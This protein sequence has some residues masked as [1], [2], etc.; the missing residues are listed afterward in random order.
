[1]LNTPA[2]I[3]LS[4]VDLVLVSV[5]SAVDSVLVSTVDS[6][7]TVTGFC[8]DVSSDVDVALTVGFAE[9]AMEKYVDKNSEVR[10]IDATK[11]EA[12]ASKR[13]HY[14]LNKLSKVRGLAQN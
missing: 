1:V 11:I 3:V 12:S 7:S 6:A 4:T 13:K 2:F 14:S 9:V 8:V 5:V 10:V